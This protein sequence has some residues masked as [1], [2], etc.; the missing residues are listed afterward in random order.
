MF[1]IAT[2][3]TCQQFLGIPNWLHSQGT[4]SWVT[5]IFQ[6]FFTFR[7][8]QGH[9]AFPLKPSGSALPSGGAAHLCPP[10]AL[11]L[12]TG[13]Q[14]THLSPRPASLFP[15]KWQLSPVSHREPSETPSLPEIPL[16]TLDQ[17][18]KSETDTLHCPP[19]GGF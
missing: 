9:L 3:S 17:T 18:T 5:F 13:V 10:R 6:S 19:R 12:R 14:R 15:S 8:A 11:R 16:S 1:L 7:V 4:C 2:H